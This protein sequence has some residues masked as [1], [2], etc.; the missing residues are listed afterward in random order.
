MEETTQVRARTHLGREGEVLASGS[1]KNT[2]AFQEKTH[3]MHRPGPLWLMTH[4]FPAQVWLWPLGNYLLME[5]FPPDYRKWFLDLV[6]LF[7]ILKGE[8]VK[9]KS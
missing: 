2:T 8:E 6:V 7:V 9:K 3:K 4:L 5:N 1:L